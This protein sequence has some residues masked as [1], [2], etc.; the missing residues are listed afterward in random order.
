[1]LPKIPKGFV[2][3]FPHAVP[4]F[5]GPRQF[6]FLLASV[7][8]FLLISTLFLAEQV[9]EP[10]QKQTNLAAFVRD[11]KNETSS[12]E[13]SGYLWKKRFFDNLDQVGSEHD[14]VKQFGLLS[15]NLSILKSDYLASHDS[16]T[17][18]SAERLATML[19][20][21][22]QKAD[23]NLLKIPCLDSVCGSITYPT[24]IEE[25]LESMDQTN[26][27][28]DFDYRNVI[29]NA[30]SDASLSTSEEEKFANYDKAF[31][32]FWIAYKN[33]K[34]PK[35]KEAGEKLLLYLERNFQKKLEQIKKDRG[36]ELFHFD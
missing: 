25:I 35:I 34:D 9:I 30:F 13:F 6:I 36:E 7:A 16:R 4:D 3:N 28:S 27:P 31:Q 15:Q 24:E 21:N 33:N 29:D 32:Y 22:F 19:N 18:I 8:V 14:P 20:E 1:M 11:F 5:I 10:R 12:L 26:F 17:R 23:P 2:T